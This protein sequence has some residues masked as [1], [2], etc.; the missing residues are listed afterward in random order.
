[1]NIRKIKL[2]EVVLSVRSTTDVLESFGI[3]QIK[4]K[5]IYRTHS[6]INR[7]IQLSKNWPRIASVRSLHIQSANVVG[8]AVDKS[9]QKYQVSCFHLDLQIVLNK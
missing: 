4:K 8:S 2:I 5:M 6:I 9:S 3:Y 7:T 1:M